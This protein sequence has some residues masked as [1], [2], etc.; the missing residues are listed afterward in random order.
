MPRIRPTVK[1]KSDLKGLTKLRN[2]VKKQASMVADVGHFGNKQH[3]E[4]NESIAEISL[5]NQQGTSKIPARPYMLIALE[6]PAF[7]KEYN[8]S[9]ERV[10][11]GKSTITKEL[12]N[13]SD[14]LKQIM[15]GVIETSFNL[16]PN[17]PI[18]IELKGS[19][20]PLI[21]TG[22]LVSD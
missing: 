8:K 16:V 19:N 1:I 9:V 12:S 3:N 5:I 21:D 15:I 11:T 6:S 10:A 4:D 20:R 7:L 18:T 2:V 22:T 17:A 13:L 14:A